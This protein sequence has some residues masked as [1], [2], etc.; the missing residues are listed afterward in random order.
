MAYAVKGVMK[1]LSDDDEL[2]KCTVFFIDDFWEMVSY[3]PINSDPRETGYMLVNCSLNGQLQFK[4]ITVIC[5]SWEIISY[6][7]INCAPNGQLQL[8]TSVRLL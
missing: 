3:M 8:L 5:Y 6:M 1:L 2:F 4:Q 7:P